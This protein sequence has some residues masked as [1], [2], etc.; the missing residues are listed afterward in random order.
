M[1][2]TPKHEYE[3]VAG[4]EPQSYVE[5]EPRTVVHS[6][7]TSGDADVNMMSEIGDGTFVAWSTCRKC[8]KR[9]GACTCAGGPVEPEYITRWRHDRFAQELNTRPEP[10]HTLLPS[11]LDWARSRGYV[12]GKVDIKDGLFIKL[13]EA[14]AAC[15]APA[16][17]QVDDVLGTF[18]RDYCEATGTPVME[19]CDECEARVPADGPTVNDA[20]ED[21]CSL[22]SDNV[23][24]DASPEDVSADQDPDNLTGMDLGDGMPPGVSEDDIDFARETL[25]A[26]ATDDEVN[27]LAAQ[28][29]DRDMGEF[30]AGF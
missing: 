19:V 13:F 29:A 18:Q 25:G 7:V 6:I 10:E 28:R 12:I 15:E 20:H 17:T 8:G 5:H 4:T 23:V 21:W 30:D 2:E 27:H 26:E 22:Y 24:D 1:S 14:V 11:V 16:G 9:V 3:V